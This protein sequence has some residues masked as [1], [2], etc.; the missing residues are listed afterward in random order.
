MRRP[1]CPEGQEHIFPPDVMAALSSHTVVAPPKLALPFPRNE[2]I[3]MDRVA[4]ILDISPRTVRRLHK[5]GHLHGYVMGRKAVGATRLQYSSLVTYCDQ[6]R[7][8]YGFPARRPPAKGFRTNPRDLLPFSKE[9]TCTLKFAMDAL[10]C[11][12]KLITDLLESGSLD[13]YRLNGGSSSW[14]IDVR[15]LE[16]YIES[17]RRQAAVTHSSVSTHR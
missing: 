13:G 14:R 15:S 1:L 9:F 17:L 11:G 2:E 16:R 12:Q 6:L 3:S 8:R 10:D 4:E 7:L 5:S